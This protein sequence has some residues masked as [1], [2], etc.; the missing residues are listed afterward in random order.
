MINP[1]I[2]TALKDASDETK[3]ILTHIFSKNYEHASSQGRIGHRRNLP[4]AQITLHTGFSRVN[5]RGTGGANKSLP[6]PKRDTRGDFERKSSM[7]FES[8]R[9]NSA[10]EMARKRPME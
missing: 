5:I 2:E 3:S 7:Y 8:L 1:K 4:N 9:L 10:V 6:R